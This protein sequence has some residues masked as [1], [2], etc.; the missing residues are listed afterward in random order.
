[1]EETVTQIERS[2]GVGRD[3]DLRADDSWVGAFDRAGKLYVCDSYGATFPVPQLVR[4]PI[5]RAIGFDRVLLV[6]SR[7][8]PNTPGG[9]VYSMAGELTA[10]LH[11]GDGVQDAVVLDDLIALTYFDEGVFSGIRPSEQGIAFFEYDGRLFDGYQSMF[12]SEAVDIVDCYAACRISGQSLAFTA[13]T[14][15][16]LVRLNPRKRHQE[17]VEIPKSVQG[18]SALSVNGAHACFF[19]PYSR[20]RALLSW[21]PR[22]APEK[23][24]SHTGPL[25]GISQHQFLSIGEHGYTIVSW[26]G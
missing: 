8:M 26:A 2:L 15:F 7:P 14:G 18:H 12:G 22:T 1:M 20:K 21:T 5:V 25:R 24:G 10:T 11:V 13:Y 23:I 19:G 4:F 6:D 16:E 17:V 9:F 3:L